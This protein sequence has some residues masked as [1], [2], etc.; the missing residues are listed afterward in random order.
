MLEADPAEAS[1]VPLMAEA[2]APEK[3]A[4]T[5]TEPAAAAGEYVPEQTIGVAL[6]QLVTSAALIFVPAAAARS[7]APTAAAVAAAPAAM[8]AGVVLNGVARPAVLRPFQ[9]AVAPAVVS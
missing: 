2:P 9:S 8:W 1:K 5:Y 4:N 6:V 7:V 3:P